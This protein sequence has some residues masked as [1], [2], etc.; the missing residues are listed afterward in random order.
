MGSIRDKYRK[1]KNKKIER[2][3]NENPGVKGKNLKKILLKKRMP[4]PKKI[5]YEKM[6][7]AH[8]DMRGK[9]KS[10]KWNCHKDAIGSGIYCED[11]GGVLDPSTA[12][13]PIETKLAVA[14][15][16]LNKFDASIH[17]L[18]YIELSQQGLSDIEIAGE[19]RIGSR[20]IMNWAT[21]YEE[22]ARAYE[23]GQALYE[24][25]WLA[26]G[27]SGLDTRNFNTNL[28]K[29]LTGNKLGYSDKIETKNL[30]INTSG[31]LKVPATPSISEWGIAEVAHDDTSIETG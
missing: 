1:N 23:I 24:S 26:K 25:W 19:M 3:L 2:V 4:I 16:P 12:L 5:Q 14:V 8:F 31:V 15:V 27:K 10:I 28:Y 9:D 21:K 7:C 18:Q 13:N 22:F 29:F 30:N 11:H 20:Q 6:K 17:P